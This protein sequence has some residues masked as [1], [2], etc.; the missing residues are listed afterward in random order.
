MNDN[1]FLLHPAVSSGNIWKLF[2]AVYNQ[3]IVLLLET[4]VELRA[5]TAAAP[6]CRWGQTL[7]EDIAVD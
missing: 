6:N 2:F 3:A 7:V 4:G 1:E 5:W